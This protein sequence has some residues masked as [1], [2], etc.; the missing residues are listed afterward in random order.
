MYFLDF[1]K[2]DKPRAAGVQVEYRL[3][4]SGE[5]FN[6]TI[7]TFDWRM[8][9][10]TRILLEHPVSLKV[11][12]QP[13]DSYPQ[14]ISARF[15]VDFVTEK[16]ESALPSHSRTFLPDGDIIED[17]CS[18]LTL[19]SRRLVTTVTKTR[20][21]YGDDRSSEISVPI[22]SMPSP[23][24]WPR[25]PATVTTTISGQTFKSND[26]PPVG[27]DE[28][29]LQKFLDELPSKSHANK[30]VYA[31]RAYKS[32]LELIV[33]RPDTAYLALVSVVETLADIAFPDFTPSNEERIQVKSKVRKRALSFGLND[34]QADAL[35][36]E[37]SV[38]DRWLSRK[39]VKFCLEYCSKEE[40]KSP[41]QV[42]IVLEHLNPPDSDFEKSLKQI[43]RA[44]STNLHVASPFPAGIGIGMSPL[45]NM[46]DLPLGIVG[47]PEI[48]PIPWFERVVSIAARN[49]LIAGSQFPFA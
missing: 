10:A 7:Q 15:K 5:L 23:V 34:S 22:L 41:D 40:I 36:L 12:S 17:L 32:A 31:A 27:V 11:A 19:L 8:S 18:I 33:N 21:Q 29:A 13:F 24:A 35:A 25:R 2:K 9:D 28:N 26:P 43:Y 49:Y 3:A 16:S 48:P 37:A 46:R 6:R 20:E 44:R 38:G 39:F 14:E 47:R 42:Y 1:L 45:V 4:C 30:I